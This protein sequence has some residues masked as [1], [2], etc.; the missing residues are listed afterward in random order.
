MLLVGGLTAA[1]FGSRV[2]LQEI[3]T[4][5]D[6]PYYEIIRQVGLAW[7]R[8]MQRIGATAPDRVLHDGTHTAEGARFSGGD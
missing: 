5:P 2:L 1:L 3:Q 4:Q 6:M 7:Q 8:L